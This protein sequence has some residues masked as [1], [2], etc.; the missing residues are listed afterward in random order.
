[1][2]V[3]RGFVAAEQLSPHFEPVHLESEEGVDN[4]L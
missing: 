1:M 3:A 4:S 2:L